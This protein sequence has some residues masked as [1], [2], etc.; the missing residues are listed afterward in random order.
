[1][2]NL[3]VQI[4]QRIWLA[5][6][7]IVLINAG[8][9]LA[10]IP[11]IEIR[12]AYHLT[13]ARFTG[14]ATYE[15][16]EFPKGD[17]LFHLPPN[18]QLA[19][20]DRVQYELRIDAHHYKT[21]LRN[22]L[23]TL[24]KPR[25]E[26]IYLARDI[27][28]SAVTVNNSPASFRI[29]PNPQLSPLK[30][31]KKALL[32]VSVR[33]VIQKRPY[34]IRIEF[35]TRFNRLPKGYQN[36]LWDFIPRPVGFYQGKWDRKSV[37]P[38][39]F[40]Q[41]TEIDIIDESGNT[42][43]S[44]R[45]EYES[46][47]PYLLLD[48]WNFRTNRFKVSFDSYFESKKV[49]LLNR[50][51]RVFNFLEKNRLLQNELGELRFIFWDGHL[52]ISGLTIFLP[53]HLFRYPDIFFKQFEINILNGIIAA[54]LNKRYVIDSNQN[55]WIFPAIQSEIFRLYFQERFSN[56]TRIFP[57]SNWLNPE[58][59]SDHSNRRWIEN[60]HDRVAVAADIS[61]DIA[62]YAH[63]YHPGIEKGFHLLWL[64][65]DGRQNFREHLLGQIRRFLKGRA[66]EQLLLSKPVFLNSFATTDEKRKT[67]EKWLAAS[68]HVDY[69][70][71]DA[72]VSLQRNKYQT[73]LDIKNTGTLSPVLEIQ[74]IFDDGTNIRK[75]I[76]T[77]AG[78][79]QF[80]FKNQPTE[81]ILDPSFNILDDDLLNNTWRF[82]IKTRMFW[83]FP[84]A[85]N[86]LLTISPL[87]GDG[88][89]FDK[90]IVGANLTY[91]YLE[92]SELSL[93]IWKGS[94]D[95]LLWTGEYFRTGYP[96]QGTKLYLETGYLRTVNSVALG[97]RQETFRIHPQLWID[98]S[99]W[100]ERL[101]A[102]EDSIFTRNQRDWA[103]LNLSSG[104]PIYQSPQNVWHVTLETLTGKSMFQPDASY[105]QFKVKQL[106]RYDLDDSNIH[107][108][109]DHGFSTGTVPLQKR[110]P[111]GGTE[112]LPGFPRTT[113]LLFYQNRII[114][115]GT[116][117][118]GIFTHT[119]INL[120][121]LLW[122]DQ[123]VSS[124]NFHYGQGITESDGTEDF[125][126]VE[127]SL[128][129]IG[130]FINRYEGIGKIAIAQ[131]VGHKKYKDYR[132]ILFSNWV[133]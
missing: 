115:I 46:P 13:S 6:A 27:H 23:K 85:D 18:W 7:V 16:A 62:Y 88:N 26:N 70:I 108:G 12:G 99:I 116:T 51:H 1:M 95:E 119:N 126:D 129:V 40:R 50:I 74:F 3:I 34:R 133:F 53:R 86:W 64:L 28:V 4:Q 97:A 25:H 47:F 75:S 44:M 87:I 111:M 36:L 22:D 80:D 90:N 37:L 125:T 21:V 121:G 24:T 100:K 92:Q 58:F 20:D 101:D 66:D 71:S 73:R 96:F 15:F 55:A 98:F 54:Y 114:E 8:T 110:Y 61:R 89:T 76:V 103:G 57:W 14:S 77:G 29:I 48:Q 107:L 38:V 84:A 30:Y 91:S 93:N 128:D 52:R 104:F 81:I 130:E 5:A 79:Y 60:K 124:L 132:I 11:T 19:N 31:N 17:L 35:Q 131:P 32:S 123:V 10:V 78:Q 42:D 39:N 43:Y 33:N 65:N 82:P 59:F 63:I 106:F 127:V 68:G 109:Y 49:N 9:A 72:D 41:L 102:L 112:G 69:T 113:D 120:L 2:C 105:Q 83:D 118:P 117:F 94:S 45:T 56:N 122:L 67:A